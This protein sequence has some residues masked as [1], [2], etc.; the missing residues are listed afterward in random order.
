MA[1]NQA[2]VVFIYLLLNTRKI[3]DNENQKLF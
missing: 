2:L 1:A 3:N